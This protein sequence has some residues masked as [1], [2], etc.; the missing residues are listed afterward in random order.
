[1]KFSKI[2]VAAL[3]AAGLIAAPVSAGMADEREKDDLMIIGCLHEYSEENGY[4]CIETPTPEIASECVEGYTTIYNEDGTISCE[5]KPVPFAVDDIKPI[6]SCWTTDDGLDVCARGAIAPLPATSEEISPE[7]CSV[8]T[9]D[10]G[11][12]SE[13]C[14]KAV[15]YGTT[16]E[17]DGGVVYVDDAPV[18]DTLMMQSGE[19]KSLATPADPTVSNAVA[20]FGVLAGLLWALVI[21]MK[22]RKEAK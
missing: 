5:V 14:Q 6:D 11:V 16:A 18:D 19:V 10:Q 21:I 13:V 2:A 20:I 15:P 17:E 7:A 1:M 8:T 9:D 12:S 3:F 22:K 4:D